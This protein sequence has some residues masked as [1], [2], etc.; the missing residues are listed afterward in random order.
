MDPVSPSSKYLGLYPNSSGKPFS[1]V[2]LTE[3][4]THQ[5]VSKGEFATW[6][7]SFEASTNSQFVLTT[8]GKQNT[9]GE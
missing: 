8:H 2:M 3:I 7:E 9:D 4:P 1:A 5:F 6:K